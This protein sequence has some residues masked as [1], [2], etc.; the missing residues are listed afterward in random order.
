[1]SPPHGPFDTMFSPSRLSE[2][3]ESANHIGSDID[4][5]LARLDLSHSVNRQLALMLRTLYQATAA[6]GVITEDEYKSRLAQVD[7][8]EWLHPEKSDS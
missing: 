4:S 7:I 8:G 5:L 2:L 3:G 1:M 6:R